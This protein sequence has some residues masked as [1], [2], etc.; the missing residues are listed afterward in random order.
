M[1]VKVLMVS[2]GL[3]LRIPAAAR[4]AFTGRVASELR[5]DVN[6]ATATLRFA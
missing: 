3:M 2:V 5:A 1:V 4:S 6:E